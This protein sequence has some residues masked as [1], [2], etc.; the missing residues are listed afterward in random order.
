MFSKNKETTKNTPKQENKQP[1]QKP[2][3]QNKPQKEPKKAQKKDAKGAKVE[4][5]L[6]D[7]AKSHNIRVSSP[8]GYYPEDV[9]PIIA[10]L[11]KTVQQLEKENRQFEAENH[12]YKERCSALTTELTKLKMQVSLM[13]IPDVSAEEGFAMLGRIDSITG[14]YN[15]ESVVDLKQQTATTNKPTQPK[16]KI[17]IKPKS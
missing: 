14:N 4:Q 3:K 17:K 11:E 12:E 10:N 2:Q 5:E 6:S 1:K 16:P 8:Y 7:L 15:S 13:E 9:D